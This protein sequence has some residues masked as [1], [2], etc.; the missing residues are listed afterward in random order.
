MNKKNIQTASTKILLIAAVIFI[1]IGVFFIFLTNKKVNEKRQ[2]KIWIETFKNPID[3]ST[4]PE[5][6]K[7]V[8]EKIQKIVSFPLKYPER[9]PEGYKLVKVESNSGDGRYDMG[10]GV[11]IY[12]EDGKEIRIVEGTG[13]L[14]NITFYMKEIETPAK[15]KVWLAENKKGEKIIT[16]DINCEKIC[17][18]IIGNKAVTNHEILTTADYLFKLSK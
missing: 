6:H 17:Y 9:L 15:H 4:Q 7:A 18:V 5:E 16:L 10:S 1:L 8:Y 13:D 3:P 2:P 14:G 11:L 12:K